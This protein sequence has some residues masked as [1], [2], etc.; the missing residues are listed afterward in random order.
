MLVPEESQVWSISIAKGPSSNRTSEF[1]FIVVDFRKGIVEMMELRLPLLIRL[2]PAKS[3]RV[4]FVRK[5]EFSEIG[6]LA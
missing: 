3:D 4:I 5:R 6:E 2:R 1:R